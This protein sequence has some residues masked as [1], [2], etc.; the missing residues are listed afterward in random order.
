MRF[1]TNYI[2]QMDSIV[3]EIERKIEAGIWTD[4][5]APHIFSAR[6]FEVQKELRDFSQMIY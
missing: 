6:D 2:E 4:S 1:L 5:D 3:P